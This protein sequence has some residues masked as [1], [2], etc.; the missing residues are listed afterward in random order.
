[1]ML[2]ICRAWL[3]AVAAAFLFLTIPSVSQAVPVDEPLADPALEARARALH[4]QIR[5]LVC[6]NQSIDDSNADLARDLR[7]VVRQR[8]SLGGSDEEVLNYLVDRYGDWVLLNPPLN[9]RTLALWLGP[10]VLLLLGGT[11]AVVVIRQQRST[12]GVKPEPLSE[13][14]QARLSALL[15]NDRDAL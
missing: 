1:M 5:C 10:V 11:F 7:I 12:Q 6:Q 3:L 4:K 14:E 8:I 15:D 2:T 9:I 13:A